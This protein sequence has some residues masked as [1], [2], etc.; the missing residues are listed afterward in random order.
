MTET[1]VRH[2]LAS[3]AHWWVELVARVPAGAWAAPGLG[4]WDIR[5]LV[6][7][8]SRSLITVDTYLDRPAEV[9]TVASSEDYY[10]QVMVF[11]T[12]AAAVAERG[13]QAGRDLGDDPATA[14]RDLAERVLP[15]VLDP[16]LSLDTAIETLAGGMRVGDYLPT[17]TFELVVHGFDLA[18]ALGLAPEPPPAAVLSEAVTLAAR[19]AVTG[20]DGPAV[21]RALTGR[22]ALASGFS[23]V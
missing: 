14:V 13:R 5:A 20:G 11:A 8:T 17:R 10:R 23:V 7:H 15:R 4:E 21:L 22:T 19:L 18:A 12:D 9:A 2:T 16:G 6:G 1:D 3:A